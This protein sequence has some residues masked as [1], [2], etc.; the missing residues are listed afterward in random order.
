MR[1][2]SELMRVIGRV[3][4]AALDRSLWPDARAEIA[5]FVVGPKVT[6]CGHTDQQIELKRLCSE[7]LSQL[8]ALTEMMPLFESTLGSGAVSQSSLPTD[9]PSILLDDEMHQRIRHLVPHIRRALL[10]TKT[11]HLKEREAAIFGDVLDGLSAGLLLVAADCRILHSNAAGRKIL[12]A[13][14]FLREVCGRLVAV[15]PQVNQTLRETF[16]CG[17][18]SVELGNTG[19]ALATHVARV[20]AKTGA[21]RQADLVKLVA[22]F[23]NLLV[24]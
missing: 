10:I 12:R 15:N 23:A 20:F 7:V 16:A 11:V 4:D 3:Y 13:E 18:G 6:K 9:E 17:S 24:A 19:V 2:D 8:K 1:E 5:H 14:N 22:G 21:A